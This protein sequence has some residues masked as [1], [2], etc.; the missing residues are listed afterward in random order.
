M[1]LRDVALETSLRPAAGTPAVFLWLC[2]LAGVLLVC[3]RGP[4]MPAKTEHS[5]Y[6]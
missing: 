1:L 4:A 5:L 6:I 2:T 3:A